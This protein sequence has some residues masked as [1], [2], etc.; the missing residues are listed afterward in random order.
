MIS[1]HSIQRKKTL[2]SKKKSKSIF[3]P[4]MAFKNE[5]PF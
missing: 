4:N 2:F 5:C 1:A 3:L